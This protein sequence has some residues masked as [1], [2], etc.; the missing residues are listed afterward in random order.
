MPPTERLRHMYSLSVIARILA[1]R[2]N[3]LEGHNIDHWRYPDASTFTTYLPER[4]L[5]VCDFI[6][7]RADDFERAATTFA[8][9]ASRDLMRQLFA[10]RAL[11]PYHVQLQPDLSAYFA[12]FAHAAQL[13]VGPSEFDM[14]PFEMATYRIET[15]DHAITAECWLGNVVFSFLLKQYFFSRDAVT[16]APSQGD[17]VI[18]AGACFGDTALA[19]AA[20]IGETGRVFSFEPVPRQGEVFKSNVWRNPDLAHRIEFYDKAVSNGLEDSLLFTDQGANSKQASDGGITTEAISVDDFVR[21]RGL[22]KVDFIKADIE[23]AEPTMLAGATE[24]IRRFK[25]RLAI[26]AYHREDD[27][28]TL[29]QVIKAIEPSYKVFLGHHTIH[30]EETII[31]AMS[32]GTG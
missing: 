17:Y 26:S 3:F 32:A 20:A 7:A 6:T 4:V 14:P 27:L 28:L 31:Y 5:L 18:D 19:F 12:A 1:M 16:I 9:D 23:G 29:P 11:G 22:D 25:P 21:D 2:H 10:F 30:S 13:R 24:T 8:D 15:A